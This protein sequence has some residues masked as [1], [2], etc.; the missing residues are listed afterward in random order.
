MLEIL[1]QS[2]G[3]E[4]PLEE[5][6]AVHSSFLPEKSHSASFH[7]LIIHLDIFLR[8]VFKSAHCC[9]GVF[10]LLLSLRVLYSRY[11]FFF[12]VTSFLL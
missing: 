2:L 9:T 3:W 5:E 8:G 4:N 11:K 7:V 1:V 10:A 12:R 6:M